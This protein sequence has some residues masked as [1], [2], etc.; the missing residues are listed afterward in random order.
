MLGRVVCRASCFQ[1]TASHLALSLAH[2]PCAGLQARLRLSCRPPDGDP[3]P[4]RLGGWDQSSVVGASGQLLGLGWAGL[5]AA[6]RSP[7]E[8]VREAPWGAGS[9]PGIGASKD[10][11]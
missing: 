5:G 6:S 1:K 3:E 11:G 8:G 10:Q 9:V 7:G 2:S 4:R